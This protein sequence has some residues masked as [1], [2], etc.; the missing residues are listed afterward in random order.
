VQLSNDE[1]S[2]LTTLTTHVNHSVSIWNS[3]NGTLQESMPFDSSLRSAQWSP[4]ETDLLVLPSRSSIYHLKQ[5]E[6]ELFTYLES[7][8][9]K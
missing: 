5:P 3:Q 7:L 1:Q 8:S 4:D 2:I 9:K 6:P